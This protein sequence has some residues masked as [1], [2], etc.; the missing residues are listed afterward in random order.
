[1][2]EFAFEFTTKSTENDF[3]TDIRYKLKVLYNM[4]YQNFQQ[5]EL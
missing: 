5:L 3:T 2:F 1:M 4:H